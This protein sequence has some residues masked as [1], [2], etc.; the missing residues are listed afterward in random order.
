MAQKP[1]KQ[2]LAQPLTP[3][4]MIGYLVRNTRTT[5]FKLAIVVGARDPD[6]LRVRFWRAASS[7]W[8]QPTLLDRAYLQALTDDEKRERRTLIARASR[9]AADFV[10]QVYS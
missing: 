5:G 7:L 1:A 8:T 4:G 10:P 6:T 9:A 3:D 2:P